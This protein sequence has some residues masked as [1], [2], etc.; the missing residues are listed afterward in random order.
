MVKLNK[1]QREFLI[2]M[3]LNNVWMAIHMGSLTEEEWH[4]VGAIAWNYLYHGK[5][6]EAHK[7]AF[8]TLKQKSDEMIETFK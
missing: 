5:L 7:T 3:Y 6:I 8:R 1:R 4:L 2:N